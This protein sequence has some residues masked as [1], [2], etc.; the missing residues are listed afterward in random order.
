MK[1]TTPPNT[2][3]AQGISLGLRGREGKDLSVQ[4]VSMF[5][6]GRRNPI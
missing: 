6:S 5:Y 4:Q 3:K 1:S 2:K